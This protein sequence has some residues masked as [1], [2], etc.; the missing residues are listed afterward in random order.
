MF[1]GCTETDFRPQLNQLGA[2]GIEVI[3]WDPPGYGKSRPP[4]RD[5]SGNFLKNDSE[6]AAALMKV[7]FFIKLIPGSLS[8]QLV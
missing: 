2:K 1:I 8:L 6:K 7:R 4:N 5:F 3:C